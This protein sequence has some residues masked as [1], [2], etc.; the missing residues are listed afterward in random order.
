MVG[1][2][3]VKRTALEVTGERS[4]YESS[5][6]VF[7]EFCLKC[8]T[9]LFYRA[10]LIVPDE[11]D[12]QSSTFDDPDAFPPTEMIQMAEAPSW[13]AALATLPQHARFPREE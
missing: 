3:A 4:V 5:P 13:I 7:R 9:G 12:V 8:G 6:N 10:D 11:L 1:W 2:A